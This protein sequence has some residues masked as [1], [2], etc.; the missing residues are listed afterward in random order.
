MDEEIARFLRDGPTAAELNEAKVSERAGYIRSL[1][2]IGGFGGKS[3]LLARAQVFVDDPDYPR[4][5]IIAG[6]RLTIADI[7]SAA[8]RW[9][10]DGV[11]TLEVRPFAETEVAAAGA[12]RSKMP[13][14]AAP[15]AVG[16]PTPEKATLANGLKVQLVR[17]S[18]V[19]VLAMRLLLDAGYAADKGL[20]PGTAQMTL[21]MLDEGT[22][23][24]TSQQISDQL[25]A[26]GAELFTGSQV[27][28]S[29]VTLYSL[30]DKIDPALDI[31]ADVVL[32]PS[33]PQSDLERIKKNTIATIQ[34]EKVQPIGIALRVLP[35]LIYGPGHAYGTPLTG[36]GTE[37]SAAA[38]TREQLRRF[39]QTWFKPNNA[40]MIVVGDITMAELA[41]KLE[42]AFASWTPGSVP[43]K[44]ITEVTSK[45]R[46][47]VYIL[48]RPGA[49]Q[50]LLISA[51]LAPPKRYD[52]EFA[53]QSFNDAFGG[54]FVS[55]LNMNL[56]ED[57]HWS[58]GAGAFPFDARG[59]RLWITYA[60]VQTDKTKESLQEVVKELHEV[61]GARPMTAQEIKDAIDRQTLTLAGRWETGLAVVNSLMEMTT[62][63]L[64]EDYYRTYAERVRAVTPEAVAASV[65]EVVRPDAQ[66]YVVVGDRAKIES[67]VRSLNLGEVRFIDGDG[68]PKSPTP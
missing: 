5:R 21:E 18:S 40:T 61:A 37:E 56:R 44:A 17:R 29:R 15:P 49:E 34:Q 9:L 8:R 45:P 33:F 6:Q 10:S 58:Y 46:S 42:R 59:Q 52:K 14:V 31:F 57:K 2:R 64:P 1:E 66:V 60:S 62:F 13:D 54:A 67:G 11:Y 38:M 7:Q 24:R 65:R 36:S 3:D 25:A 32:H 43:T 53:F 22:T 28:N 4:K 35:L 63:G 39:H 47:E 19:P 12:D 48:D 26:I 55:R 68:R 27:D 23:T 16:F 30:R 51:Q 41:P 20:A 50:T